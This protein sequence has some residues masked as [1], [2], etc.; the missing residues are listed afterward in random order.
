MIG[1]AQ[2]ASRRSQFAGRLGIR[3]GVPPR[4]TQV[5]NIASSNPQRVKAS[6]IRPFLARQVLTAGKNKTVAKKES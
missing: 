2:W 1:D 5:D 4:Q 6:H 3:C